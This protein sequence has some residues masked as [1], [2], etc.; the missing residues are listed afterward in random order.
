MGNVTAGTAS[1]GEDDETEFLEDGLE[2]NFSSDDSSEGAL[3]IATLFDHSLLREA[4]SKIKEEPSE[5][6]M[7]QHSS[8]IIRWLEERNSRHE[9][10][11]VIV[12]SFSFPFIF[13]QV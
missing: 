7:Q 8:S 3:D 4:A 9:V 1:E 11:I 12:L 6:F 10:I 2:T 5:T 13:A